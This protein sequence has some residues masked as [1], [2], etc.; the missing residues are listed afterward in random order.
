MGIL[1]QLGGQ[2]VLPI[3]NLPDGD[4]ALRVAE[5]LVAGGIKVFEITLR[6]PEALQALQAVREEFP[7]LTLGAGTLIDK[8]EIARVKDMGIDFGVSPGWSEELW[9]CSLEVN[10]PLFPGILTPTELLSAHQ[11]GCRSAEGFPDRTCRRNFLPAIFDRSLPAFGNPLSADG[12]NW[13]RQSR[14]IPS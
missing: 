4:S 14:F 1:D 2:P 12:R 3:L 13:A 5:A 6:N 10:L 11:A 7:D 9:A 8:E